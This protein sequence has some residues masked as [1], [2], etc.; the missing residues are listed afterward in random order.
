[1]STQLAGNT[2]ANLVEVE[3]ASKAM[4]AVLRPDD[5]GSLGI[6][7]LAAASSTMTAG[8]AANSPIF[9]FRWGDAT[10]FALLKR[11]L[12]S[13]G[14]IAAFTAGFCTFQAFKAT[15]FSASDTGGTSLAPG[16]TAKLRSSTMGSSL[17]TDVRMSSTGTLTAGTRTLDSFPFGSL[18]SSVVATAGTPPIAPNFL[19]QAL[20]GEYPEVFAQNEGFIIQATVPATGTWVFSVQ[21]VW[22][23]LT[24][25]S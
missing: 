7:S 16:A 17:I 19:F 9:S 1:M 11:L 13:A 25:Y 24:A 8:L 6:Y 5:Y 22:E 3:T 4:R 20:P 12:S 15:S 23:E 21:A 14:S 10:R 2:A 18:N